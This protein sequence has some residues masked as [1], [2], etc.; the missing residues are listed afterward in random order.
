MI[1][2][3]GGNGANTVMA[4]TRKRPAQSLGM[5]VAESELSSSEYVPQATSQVLV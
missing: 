1:H 3:F 2:N 4:P 5:A